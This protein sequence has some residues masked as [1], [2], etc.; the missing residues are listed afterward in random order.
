MPKY[1]TEFSSFLFLSITKAAEKEE[2]EKF[3]WKVQEVFKIVLLS[4]ICL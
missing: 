4:S 1:K 3:E 2:V